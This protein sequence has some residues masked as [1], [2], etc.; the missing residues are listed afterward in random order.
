MPIIDPVSSPYHPY[1]HPQRRGHTAL[2]F[3]MEKGNVAMVEKLI[4]AKAK[5]DAVDCEG[6]GPGYGFNDRLR[7]RILGAEA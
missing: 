7:R 3:A 4:S 6:L 5:V 1:P 2:H